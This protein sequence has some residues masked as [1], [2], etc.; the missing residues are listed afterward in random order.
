MIGEVF[1]GPIDAGLIARRFGDARLQ[2]VRHQRQGHAADGREGV[3]M[4]ADPIRQRLRPAGFRI[5]VIRRPEGGDKNAST[6]FFTGCRI[7]N[8]DRVAGPVDEQLLAHQMRLPHRRRDLLFP[9]AIKI[10]ITAV[11][12]AIS[13]VRPV[14]L[15]EEQQRHAAPLQFA[16]DFRPIDSGSRRR[17]LAARDRK[18]TALQLFIAEPLWQRPGE[19]DDG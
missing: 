18:K 3:D 15:P 5:G 11:A 10:A 14:L 16:L 1:I 8:A 13:M 4:G 9:V 6:M 19:A 2:V 12:V 7:D 17:A